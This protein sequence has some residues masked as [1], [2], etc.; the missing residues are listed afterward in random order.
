MVIV[1]ESSQKNT[2]IPRHIHSPKNRIPVLFRSTAPMKSLIMIH[3][4]LYGGPPFACFVYNIETY[5]KAR[6]TNEAVKTFDSLRL[7]LIV[8]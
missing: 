6:I 3:T 4:V 5:N 7:A 2:N 1:Y 8:S